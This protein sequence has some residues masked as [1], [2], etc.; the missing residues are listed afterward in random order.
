VG[1]ALA[2]SSNRHNGWGGRMN[3]VGAGRDTLRPWAKA[4]PSLAAIHCATQLTVTTN[5]IGGR[6]LPFDLRCGLVVV[7]VTQKWEE[8]RARL[9]EP[10]YRVEMFRYEPNER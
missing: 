10:C 5:G 1:L 3:S 7:F 8:V 2:G 9:K 6:L 4:H